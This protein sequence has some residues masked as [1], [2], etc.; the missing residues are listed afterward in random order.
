V[1]FEVLIDE[2]VLKDDFK[3]IDLQGGLETPSIDFS[4]E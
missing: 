4:K 2:L 3:K 1:I